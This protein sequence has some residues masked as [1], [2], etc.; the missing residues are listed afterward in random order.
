MICV[1]PS[2]PTFIFK[3]L[4]KCNRPRARYPVPIEA[5]TVDLAFEKRKKLLLQVQL[6]RRQEAGL[7]SVSPPR[8]CGEI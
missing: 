5:N 6:A 3:T 8:V 4:I 7:K 1:V 2:V